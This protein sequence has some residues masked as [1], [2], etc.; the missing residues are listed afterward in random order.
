MNKKFK[1]FSLLAF[2]IIALVA[3]L[4][5]LPLFRPGFFVS[6]DGGW[7]VVRL[8]AFYQSLR[9]G[10][11]PVR[12][13]GRLNY[14]YG[15]PVANF[16]YPGFLYIGSFIHFLGLTFIDTVKVILGGSIVVGTLFTYLWLSTYYSAIPSLLGAISF[17]TAPY[18]LFDIY[19][20]GSVGEVLAIAVVSMGLYA[21]KTNKKWLLGVS[22]PL[23]I[24]SH[25]T[26]ALLFL[27]F[28][29]VYITVLGKW[30]E[31][32][33]MFFTG[34]AMATFFWLPALNE[35]KYV[36]FDLVTV[37]NPRQFFASGAHIGLLSFVGIVG[38]ITSFFV[39][40]KSKEKGFFLISFIIL[41]FL[42]TPSS[43]LVWQWN[44]LNKIIQFP[45]R[46]LSLTL[47]IEAWFIAFAYKNSNKAVGMLLMILTISIG[48][49]VAF[50]RLSKVAQLNQ[51]EGFYTTNEATTNVADEYMPKWVS[52]KPS[53]HASERLTFYEGKGTI[54]A[55]NIS[56]QTVD[57]V[58]KAEEES[59]IQ[60]NTVFYPGWGATID[61]VKVPL[62]YSQ[63][64]GLIRI[65]VP[66]GE[67][68]L[69]LSF[70]ET[71]SRFA[72]DIVS[73]IGVIVFIILLIKA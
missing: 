59:I 2:V 63:K 45:Y 30:R 18:F 10:Q 47:F 51:P 46:L 20:R 34:I 68:H 44:L 57:A 32:Y 49:W 3:I 16:L 67:H 60:I 29:A 7:M 53:N 13:L 35:R 12:F 55:K 6:D 5:S 22:I 9:E 56:L 17:V 54:T 70:R 33:A 23:L 71:I 43:S 48:F 31:L 69:I 27:G 36:Y 73:L 19:Q 58:I 61:D 21:I 40:K 4:I 66:A 65:S 52:S 50:G 25:N 24:L 28:F 8:S 64:D 41:L 26:L 39:G 11:F 1:N 62:D 72:S 14:G 15:Y 37:A 42:V 38:A